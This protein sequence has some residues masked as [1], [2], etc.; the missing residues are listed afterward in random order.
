M[1]VREGVYF[2]RNVFSNNQHIIGRLRR[3]LY[4]GR[5]TEYLFLV[6]PILT[7]KQRTIHT[8]QTQNSR[9]K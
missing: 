5:M 3:S 7:E 1:E 2:S 9:N 4:V 6:G 8:I